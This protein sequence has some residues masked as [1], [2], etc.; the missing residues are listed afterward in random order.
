MWHLW[1]QQIQS[2]EAT[3]TYQKFVKN[4]RTSTE[5]SKIAAHIMADIMSNEL[6]VWD[7]F[8]GGDQSYNI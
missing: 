8:K 6:L 3:A 2:I 4:N 7:E 1:V 5:L